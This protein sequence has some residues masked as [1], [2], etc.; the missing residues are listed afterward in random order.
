MRNPLLFIVFISLISILQACTSTK[1]ASPDILLANID[2]TINPANDFFHY[3]CGNWLKSNPIPETESSWGIADLVQEETYSRLREISENAAKENNNKKGSVLQKIGDFFYSG[4]DTFTIEKSRLTPLKPEMDS[5]DAILSIPDLL[6][7]VALLQTY[8]ISS[9]F[10]IGVAQDLMNSSKMAFYIVQG[11]LGLPNRDYYYNTDART[12]N[13]RKEYEC[14]VIR[15]LLLSGIDSATAA[16]KG[17]AVVQIEMALANKSRRIEELRDPRANY[18]KISVKNLSNITPSINWYNFLNR[19]NVV[20]TDTVI[21][22]QPEFFK[23]L[24]AILKSTPIDSWKAYLRWH[25][26]SNF[27]SCL[28]KD[29]DNEQFSFYGKVL[30][31]MPKNRDRWKRVLDNEES[32]IGELLGQLYVSKYF[33]ASTKMRYEILVDNIL[34]AYRVRIKKLDWMSETTKQK[35]LYKLSN[36][37]KKVGYP[38]KW[39]DYSALEINRNSYVLNVISANKWAYNYQLNKL[40]KP[41]DRLE[42]SM[43]PQTYN[44]YYNSSNNEIVLPAAIFVIP[45]LPDSLADDAIIYAYSGGSTIGHEITHGFDDMGCMFDANGNLNNW[46]TKEDKEKFNART[47]GMVTQFNKYVVLDSMHV[48]GKASLGENIADLAG[49]AIGYDAFMKTKRAR[50]NKEIDG[51]SPKQRFFLGYALAWIGHQRNESLARQIMTD[52]H[53][54]AFL[55]VN[56]PLSNLPEFYN[57]FNVKLGN[58]MYRHDSI[59]VQIW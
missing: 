3:A 44:A 13:I 42:W 37:V 19:A 40:H 39:A 27:A 35:A 11:G 14:H 58:A 30:S 47:A 38:D 18:N 43:T 57:A 51:F 50:D 8:Q 5:I 36:V 26:L 22:G 32:E 24:E 34:D 6:R 33:S 53:A 20:K 48:N 9:I 15:M 31:G 46:W 2:T 10:N 41:V 16:V 7:V 55:R 45:G 17:K 21:V 4:M 25:L 54:P 56:G 59:R 28:N 1:T 23:E 49:I 52:V 29:I 12:I